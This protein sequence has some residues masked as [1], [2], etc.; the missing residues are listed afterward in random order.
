MNTQVADVYLFENTRLSDLLEPVANCAIDDSIDNFFRLSQ[1]DEVISVGPVFNRVIL[2]FRL[3]K[4]GREMFKNLGFLFKVALLADIKFD[5]HLTVRI[6][7]SVERNVENELVAD[8]KCKVVQR[9]DK[10]MATL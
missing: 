1:H 4:H 10:A 6:L 5:R 7:V 3:R 8:A 2:G 9:C